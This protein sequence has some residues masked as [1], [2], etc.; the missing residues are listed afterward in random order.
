MFNYRD[1]VHG[2][3]KSVNQFKIMT[4]VARVEMKVLHL[5]ESDVISQHFLL[6]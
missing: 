5:R 1:A 6:S 3:I 4:F 2:G